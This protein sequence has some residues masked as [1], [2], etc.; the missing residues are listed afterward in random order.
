MSALEFLCPLGGER[1]L[2]TLKEAMIVARRA[3]DDLRAAE[4]SGLKAKLKRKFMANKCDCGSVIGRKARRCA[5]CYR[6]KVA[7]ET[8]E[9]ARKPE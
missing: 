3:G 7:R 2:A 4:L 5:P 6:V 1:A 9:R 8:R